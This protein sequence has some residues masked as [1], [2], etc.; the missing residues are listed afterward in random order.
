LDETGK[1]LTDG[2]GRIQLSEDGLSL[3]PKFGSA[4]SYSLLEILDISAKDY[5]IPLTL[6][7]KENLILY[8]LGYAYEDFLRNLF[9][10]RNEKLLK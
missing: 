10:L 9:K 8:H 2:E 7:S 3:L 5:R 4:L 6:S 1:T